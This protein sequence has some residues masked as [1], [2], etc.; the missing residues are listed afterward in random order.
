VVFSTKILRTRARPN[1]LFR[2]RQGLDRD[3]NTQQRE[4][5][6][7]MR[8][9]RDIKQED[10]QY[11]ITMSLSSVFKRCAVLTK[12][13]GGLSSFSGAR[14]LSTRRND[15]EPEQQK[16]NILPVSAIFRIAPHILPRTPLE[17]RYEWA[18]LPS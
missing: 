17:R 3:V 14:G 11:R 4:R 2:E 16:D 12:A 15:L 10:Y 7:P 13:R 9:Q 1:R 6:I 18:I 5:L 8:S